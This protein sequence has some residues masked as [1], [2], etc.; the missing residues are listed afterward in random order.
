MIA[1]NQN[2]SSDFGCFMQRQRL[3]GHWD[4]SLKLEYSRRLEDTDR[5]NLREVI[6]S[7]LT[8]KENACGSKVCRKDPKN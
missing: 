3:W 5:L 8:A 2:C 7:V 1:E 4:K 6:G